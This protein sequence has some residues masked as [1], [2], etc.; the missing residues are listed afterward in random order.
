M[1]ADRAS[2][3]LLSFTERGSGPP[4]LLVH[5]LM[6]TGA[7]VDS[8]IEHMAT[9]QRGSRNTLGSFVQRDDLG[10]D[11]LCWPAA[12]LVDVDT[13][14]VGRSGA[15]N[16]GW[17]GGSGSVGGVPLGVSDMS[18]TSGMVLLVLL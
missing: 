10:L 17:T 1:N 12:L 6:V 18:P 2:S 13:G 5:G 4:L 15:S 7:M 14:A 8:V 3:D 9:R 11:P 16:E